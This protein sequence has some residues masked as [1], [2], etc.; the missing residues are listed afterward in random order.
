MSKRGGRSGG[1][2]RKINDENELV[3]KNDKKNNVPFEN[4]V[5]ETIQPKK[6]IKKLS[7]DEYIDK[8]KIIQYLLRDAKPSNID[9]FGGEA[10][11]ISMPPGLFLKKFGYIPIPIND[12]IAES[13]TK[14]WCPNQQDLCVI[15]ID[16]SNAEIR[17]PKWMQSLNDLVNRAAEGLNCIGKIAPKFRKMILQ[18]KV[19]NNCDSAFSLEDEIDDDVFATLVI[20]LP[21]SYTGK[22]IIK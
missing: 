1:F 12:Q 3:E 6:R 17:N 21:S 19:S 20:Q 11:E 4:Q 14:T 8:L 5:I 18:K 7:D 22:I 13:I 16:S 15:S 9:S 10:I 2:K